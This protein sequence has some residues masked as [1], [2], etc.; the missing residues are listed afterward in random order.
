MTAG[1]L[2]AILL[3]ALI[4]GYSLLEHYTNVAAAPPGLG[5]AL[6]IAPLLAALLL[7][8]HRTRWP[9]LAPLVAALAAVALL[10]PVWQQLEHGFSWIYLLQQCGTYLLLAATFG[11]S[12]LP[13][14]VPL[15]S[16]WAAM[17]HGS[18]SAEHE[19]YARAVTTAWTA[20]FVLIVVLS[21]A[22]YA[23]APRSAWSLFS[24][25]LVLPLAALMFAG[26]YAVRR[27]RLPSMPRVSVAQT[28]RVYLADTRG[29]RRL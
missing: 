11:R 15:C 14:R 25:F 13:G 18:L 19:R 10:V 20:F 16:R 12:L 3:A 27:L 2:R 24:N 6:A 17:I 28:M 26:E 22:L 29:L 4:L 21:A 5:A 1:R 9:W 7:L 8:A 23:F